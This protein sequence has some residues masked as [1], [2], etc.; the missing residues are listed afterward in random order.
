MTIR[1]FQ[2]EGAANKNMEE[3]LTKMKA[4]EIEL[5][6]KNVELEQKSKDL[7]K[8]NEE[9]DVRIKALESIVS[10]TNGPSQS[11]NNEKQVLQD[12]IKKLQSICYKSEKKIKD[13]EAKM[14][15][16]ENQRR[17][18]Q[19]EIEKQK[20]I[21]EAQN[22]RIT[23]LNA[24]I[25]SHEKIEYNFRSKITELEENYKAT[26]ERKMELKNREIKDV[27]E[28]MKKMADEIK[29]C[30]SESVSG[31]QEQSSAVSIL[32]TPAKRGRPRK[33]KVAK[34]GGRPPKAIL[35]PTPSSNENVTPTATVSVKRGRPKKVIPLQSIENKEDKENEPSEESPAK[36]G[37]PRKHVTFFSP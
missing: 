9:K 36:R 22:K 14:V 4:V 26:L 15:E 25:K 24:T 23:E 37:R 1:G 16:T 8:D 21:V 18:Y 3:K 34:R 30:K 13:L 29:K 28:Q 35:P 5:K 33:I 32:P 27:K 10:T 6:L 7:A 20:A 19:T 17:I 12:E 2:K 11:S 31:I